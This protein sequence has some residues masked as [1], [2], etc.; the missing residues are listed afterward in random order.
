MFSGGLLDEV[1][2]LRARGYGKAPVVRD[3]IGYHEAG[4][5]IDG[6]LSPRDAIERA[7]IRTRQY[8]KRQRTYI[9]GRG[10]PMLKMSELDEWAK[11]IEPGAQS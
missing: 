6:A 10:W 8:A 3:G 2:G 7:A 4:Q 1:S 9:R 11:G 5:V